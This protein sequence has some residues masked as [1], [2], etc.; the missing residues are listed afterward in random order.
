MNSQTAITY[1]IRAFKVCGMWLLGN[2]SLLYR[3]WSFIYSLFVC[4]IFPISAV[5]CVFFAD[6]VEV[7]VDHLFISSTFIMAA[8]KGFNVFVKLKTFSQLFQLMSEL[9]E[10][11]TPEEHQKIFL[12]IFKQS[13][14]LFLFFCGNY[15]ASW[16]F[17][18]FQVLASSPE[19]RMWSSTYLYPIEFL[20]HPTIY[21]GGIVFQGIA[22]FLLVIFGIA[23]DSYPASLLH[24]LSGHIS[25]LGNRMSNI[26]DCKKRHDSFGEK[27]ELITN[28]KR[29]I[30][31]S[32]LQLE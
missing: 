17:I 16:L 32:R 23:L 7:F 21:M 19:K 6:S 1:H 15:G 8:I 18:L 14:G 26:A 2:S 10:T 31:I 12:P 20:H 22:N 3:L 25:V 30:L 13:N 4:I 27:Q 9:D 29:Y 5:I 24:V 28:C 11:I